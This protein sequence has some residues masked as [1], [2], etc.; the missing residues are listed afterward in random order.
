M[1]VRVKKG[2]HNRLRQP[3]R[4]LH[5]EEVPDNF[6]SFVSFSTLNHQQRTTA[7]RGIDSSGGSIK[8]THQTNSARA[9]LNGNIGDRD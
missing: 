7:K 4:R 2:G 1:L 6:D 8:G 5:R 9:S 3:V